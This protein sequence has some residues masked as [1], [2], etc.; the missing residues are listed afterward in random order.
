[1]KILEKE[2]KELKSVLANLSWNQLI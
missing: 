2:V 1:L